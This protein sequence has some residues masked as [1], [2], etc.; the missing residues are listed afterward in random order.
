MPDS[1]TASPPARRRQRSA[2]SGRSSGAPKF[3]HSG[4]WNDLSKGRE[5]RGGGGWIATQSGNLS[6][7]SIRSD[8]PNP[9]ARAELPNF[10]TADTG[11]ISPRAE[12]IVA[13]GGG[14]PLSPETSALDRS[15]RIGQIRP[16]ERSSQIS[17]QRTLERS[18][19]GPRESWR[20]GV[21]RHSVRKP[22]RSIDQIGSAKSGRS[23]G[24]PKF[25]HSGH[26]NDLSKG[27]ENRGGGGWIAT[28]SGNL[29]ARSI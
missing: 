21:D 5:N 14:S 13:G 10:Y 24:A 15:D 2:K 6:A 16:L 4:H 12:R 26:W 23:S 3:L 27:R 29:S 28:Q 19:Q 20:G 7:R 1:L 8:R 11:T 9:A 18:L 22:Q 17:T 25:L